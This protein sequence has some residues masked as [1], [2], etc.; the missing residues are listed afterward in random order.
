M[1]RKVQLSIIL[2]VYNKQHSLKPVVSTLTTTIEQAL[3]ITDYEIIIIDDASTDNTP[4]ILKELECTPGMHV[5]YN[6][7]NAGQLKSLET[8]L[9]AATGRYT[10]LSSCDLQNPLEKLPLLYNALET[11]YDCAIAYRV[12]R[13]EKGIN[14]YLAKFFWLIISIVFP[15]IPKGGFDFAAISPDV[16]NN[17]LKKD[18]SEIF[19]QIEMI[20]LARKVFYLP[21]ERKE[22][23]LDNSTWSFQKRAIYAAKVIKYL[24]KR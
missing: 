24:Y 21:V 9:K 15:K 12:L 3:K 13:N 2:A 5:I 10:V 7:H 11:G 20:Q 8:G 18:F 23:L 1:Q 17:L 4:G 16:K 14:N 19:L 6:T 22:D